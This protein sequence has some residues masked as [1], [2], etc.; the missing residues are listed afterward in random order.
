MTVLLFDLLKIYWNL[1]LKYRLKQIVAIT[2]GKITS[3]DHEL[4]D[5]YDKYKFDYTERNTV[6]VALVKYKSV[7]EKQNYYE[8]IKYL[9]KANLESDK[10]E[11]EIIL[12][13]AQH[14]I[15]KMVGFKKW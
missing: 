7:F 15:A 2:S 3:V 11:Q 12:A 1:V 5:F 13:R 6:Y 9:E 10:D 8:W 14:L 4:Y